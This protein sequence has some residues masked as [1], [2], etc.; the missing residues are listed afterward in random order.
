MKINILNKSI[1]TAVLISFAFI[2]FAQSWEV[3]AGEKEKTSPVPFNTK[4]KQTGKD[5]FNKNCKSCHGEI[6]KNN[7]V[8]LTPNPD[9]PASE[10][11]SKNADGELFYKITNGRGAMPKFK[12]ILSEN[13]RWAVISYI[14]SF[15]KDYKATNADLNTSDDT[16]KGSD[17]SLSVNLDNNNHEAKVEVKGIV[18]G[19]TKPANGV[20]LG[21]FIKR[22]FGLLPVCE[23]ITT[24]ANG[25]ASATFPNDLPG[26]SL[27]KYEMVIKLI[28]NDIYGDVV[29]TKNINWGKQFVYENPLNHRAMWGNRGN[30]PVWLLITYF[31]MLIS[32][33]IT[34]AWVMLQLK[35]LKSLGK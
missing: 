16:F 13:D 22:N 27:G 26:D 17:L 5:I 1:L 29:Y 30:A 20:R 7:S 11:F 24:D 3:P 31:T 8:A 25:I 6:G 19:E 21:F 12:D 9:D 35:K 15:H 34:I 33:L 18:D 10:K 32:A 23:P 28:D 4:M 14:R 2:T